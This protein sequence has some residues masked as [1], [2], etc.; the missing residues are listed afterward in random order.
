MVSLI[1]KNIDVAASL[2]K[3]GKLVA[4]P[5]ETVYGLAA[6]ALDFEAVVQ[7]FSVKNRPTF[8]PLI[9]H[10]LNIESLE[11][12]VLKIPQKA[13]LLLERFSPGP[14]TLLLPKTSLIPD[15][16]TSGSH[17]VAVRIPS[18]PMTLELLRKLSFPLA[19]PSANPFGYIS[20]TNP[21]HVFD[22]LGGK[23]PYILDGGSSSIGV[24]STIVCIEDDE[25][26]LCRFG[27]IPQEEIEAVIGKVKVEANFKAPGQLKSH[28]APKKPI[29]LGNIQK[30]VERYN[31]DE[32]AI[33]SLC[34]HYEGI[35]HQIQLAPNGSLETAAH[36]L[37]SAMRTLDCLPVKYI[38]A[39]SVPNEGL[40]RA[41]NDRLS[42][43]SS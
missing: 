22:Q 6:N 40:G 8:D 24:E 38:L 20:P 21:S 26:T 2:L 11:T 9:V 15:I 29:I 5:T 1:G 12:Y 7:I 3:V 31:K 23:I 30:N 10:L 16:V 39:E 4:I 28:Y 34:T 25:A 14:L 42:R 18:H 13:L 35:S 41:I 36:T 19:A 17:F 37:F 32:I 43:A 33:L 27:G